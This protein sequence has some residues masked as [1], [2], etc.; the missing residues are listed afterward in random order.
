MTGVLPAKALLFVL[1]FWISFTRCCQLQGHAA[2]W[3][4]SAAHTELRL[5]HELLVK[6]AGD[7][8]VR[9]KVLDLGLFNGFQS[10]DQ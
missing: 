3:R 10:I 7:V 6:I 4:L 5:N 1:I 2:R 8:Q 9:F